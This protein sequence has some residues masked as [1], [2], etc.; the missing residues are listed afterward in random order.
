MCFF[1][2]SPFLVLEAE[3]E[4]LC[5]R[6]SQVAKYVG[7]RGSSLVERLDNISCI[8]QDIINF[9]VYVAVIALVIEELHSSCGLQD[10]VDFP[11]DVLDD[12]LD[13][14]LEGYV[15]AASHVVARLS[16]DDIVRKAW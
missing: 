8:I 14:V 5:R 3:L 9:S 13:D 10:V 15:E 11:L 12:G 1:F 2:P 16:A 6:A 4:K 7:A